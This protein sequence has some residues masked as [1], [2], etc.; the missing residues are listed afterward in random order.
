MAHKRPQ[1][2]VIADGLQAIKTASRLNEQAL[3]L[4]AG[5][6]DLRLELDRLVGR[7]ARRDDRARDTARAAKGSLCKRKVDPSQ[8][9]IVWLS[10]GLR[11]LDGTKT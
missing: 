11:T 8:L 2:S 4:V 7:D 5:R 6:L 10:T 3:N 1:G 9:L